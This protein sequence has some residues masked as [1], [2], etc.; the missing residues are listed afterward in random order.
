[1][2]I[3][4][5]DHFL[6]II[7][8]DNRRNSTL[9]ILCIYHFSLFARV[10]FTLVLSKVLIT[11]H[12]EFPRWDSTCLKLNSFSPSRNC[13]W[14]ETTRDARWLWLSWYECRLPSDNIFGEG[15]LWRQLLA[16]RHVWTEMNLVRAGPYHRAKCV[17]RTGIHFPFRRQQVFGGNGGFR[18]G[19][20]L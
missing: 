6:S 19:R 8:A 3:W 20:A 11:T 18:K 10:Q 4:E 1:M 2:G 7:A 14:V 13:H 12:I 16:S 17:P 5:H 9:A 15:F